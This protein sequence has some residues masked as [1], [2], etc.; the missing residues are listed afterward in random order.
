MHIFTRARTAV[1]RVTLLAG[2]APV[3]MAHPGHD[4]DRAHVSVLVAA[5]IA[6]A[7]LRVMVKR[8]G[9]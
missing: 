1:T 6:L 9:T 4:V 5:V 2:F 7:V 3:A 8:R